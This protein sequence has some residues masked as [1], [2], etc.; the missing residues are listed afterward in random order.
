M[1]KILYID[2]DNVLVDFSIAFAHLDLPIFEDQPGSREKMGSC[3]FSVAELLRGGGLP[4]L[5]VG[6]DL[7]SG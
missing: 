5:G 4:G 3:V 1:R 7:V 2:M 6:G